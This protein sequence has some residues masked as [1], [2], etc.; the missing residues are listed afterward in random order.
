M[1]LRCQ[2]GAGRHRGE[3]GDFNRSVHD[4][5]GPFRGKNSLS[6]WC[7]GSYGVISSQWS[8]QQCQAG[9]L[10]R[11]SFL[12]SLAFLFFPLP[13]NNANNANNNNN[14]KGVHCGILDWRGPGGC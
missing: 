7:V 6:Y 2:V 4:R 1:F 3:R 13:V 11:V 10:G 8:N 12:A 9:I 5:T 14:A